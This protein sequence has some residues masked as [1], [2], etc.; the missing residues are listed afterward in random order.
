MAID[1]TTTLA[2]NG[3]FSAFSIVSLSA[4]DVLDLS[5]SIVRM[6]PENLNAVINSAANC[7]FT[8]IKLDP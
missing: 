2:Y 5:I 4:G 7:T 8:V 6:L 3:R 1:D